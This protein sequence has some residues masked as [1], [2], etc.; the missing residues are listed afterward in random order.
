MD[1][2]SKHALSR[3]SSWLPSTSRALNAPSALPAA[4]PRLL[5]PQ[6]L[7]RLEGSVLGLGRIILLV[8]RLSALLRRVA[9]AV[10]G[11][12]PIYPPAL[13]RIL[14]PAWWLT[15]IGVAVHTS[16]FKLGTSS[17][18]LTL[19][20]N[21]T[22]HVM[23]S[24]RTFSWALLPVETRLSILEELADP[25]GHSGAET[26]VEAGQLQPITSL[27]SRRHIARYAMVCKEWQSCFEKALFGKLI[28]NQHDFG[29]LSRLVPRQVALIR[30]V[31]LRVELCRYDCPDCDS[32]SELGRVINA[33]T[34]VTGEA[35]YDL[36]CV[37][38]AW[39]GVLRQDLTLELSAHS[40]SDSEHHFKDFDF[41]D[42]DPGEQALGRR[43]IIAPDDPFHGWAG[44]QRM[45]MARSI[46]RKRVDKIFAFPVSAFVELPIVR[47]VTRL[48]LRRQTRRAWSPVTLENLF[49]SLP[50]LETIWFEWWRERWSGGQISRDEG[51][52]AFV[53]EAHQ[54]RAL[55]DGCYQA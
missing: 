3:Q 27:L 20:M 44:G 6:S 55:A 7:I 50:R 18:T 21:V 10:L 32:G 22:R 2:V 33:N 35:V 15:G 46:T 25:R 40:P 38:G 19:L 11:T 53:L 52:H 34:V 37:L 8:S 9:G 42:D 4:R 12:R 14:P 5:P 17:S 16:S 36:F 48:L 45:P 29:A 28:L 41:N 26:R 54:A 23:D 43:E 31:W 47:S 49:K 30:H 24:D 51:M 39:E 13:V 1:G